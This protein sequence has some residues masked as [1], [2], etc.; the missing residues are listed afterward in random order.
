MVVSGAGIVAG[1]TVTNV[2]GGDVIT[3]SGPL[4]ADLKVLTQTTAAGTSPS[5]S[6]TLSLAAANTGIE[7]GMTVSGTGIV[8]G[9]TVAAYAGGTS[10]YLSA[11]TNAAITAGTLTFRST[12]SFA[13]PLVNLTH[14]DL[15]ATV[16][17]WLAE[18]GRAHV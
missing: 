8:A 11:A 10:L 5:G 3:L 12:L 7:A 15:P 17:R 14:E 6:T 4:G 18:I 16:E 13:S 1:T 2:A 9:T